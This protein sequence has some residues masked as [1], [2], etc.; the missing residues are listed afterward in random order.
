MADLQGVLGPLLDLFDADLVQ[1]SMLL[2]GTTHR[3]GLYALPMGQSSNHVHVWSNFLE[4]AGFTLADIPDEWDWFWSFWCDRVQPG[5]RKALGRDDLWGVGLSMSAASLETYDQ[6]LQF[7]LAYDASW[8]GRDHRLRIDDPD[9]R[10]GMVRA[11]DDYTSIWQKGCAPPDS[12]SA[13][14]NNNKAFL[15]QRV[16]MTANGTLSIIGAL[17]A[18][19]AEDYYHN[20]VTI[21][22]PNGANGRPLVIEGFLARA[23]VFTGGRNPALAE[24]FVRFLVGEGWLVHWLTFGG[25]R[26]MPPMRKLLDQPFW[27]DPTDPHRMRA[28]VQ[29]LS[30]S[31]LVADMGI[32]DH[33]WQSSRIFKENVWGNAVSRVAAD[34][35]SP[36][37]AVDEAI[38]RIKEILS[39]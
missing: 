8:L 27:L 39:E 18:K 19:R 37:Q 14:F 22:W 31:H 1:A 33:E 23:G 3:R 38:A 36:A 35:V 2:N 24:D 17:R 12:V 4:R 25:D 11:L 6:L 20:V 30:R 9:V 34:G 26:R 16:V 29:L 5:V 13:T 21:D 28:A 10:R 7:Q 15:D 32:R